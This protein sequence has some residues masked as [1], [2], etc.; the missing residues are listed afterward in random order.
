MI[1]KDQY[2]GILNSRNNMSCIKKEITSILKIVGI[3]VQTGD[4]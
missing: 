1:E 2:S 3:I 4:N